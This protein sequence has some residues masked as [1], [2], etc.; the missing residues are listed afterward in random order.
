MYFTV[1][2]FKRKRDSETSW[3]KQ[4]I[5]YAAEKLRN[6]LSLRANIHDLLLVEED[7]NF[8]RE[9][10]EEEE[11]SDS[12]EEDIFINEKVNWDNMFQPG[13]LE[14]YSQN[15]V[16]K[17]LLLKPSGGGGGDDADDKSESEESE[18]DE[19]LKAKEKKNKSKKRIS[20]PKMKWL[21]KKRK[22]E[23]ELVKRG[24]FRKYSKLFYTGCGDQ[25]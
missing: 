13:E 25:A 24:H 6:S 4:H 22:K 10:R 23:K 14:H 8:Q 7:A 17:T 12:D 21:E 11:S 1:Q 9:T 5:A 19:E 16:N 20:L 18:T 15:Y 2:K 3:D